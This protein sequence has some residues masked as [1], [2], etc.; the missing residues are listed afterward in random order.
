TAGG[1]ESRDGWLLEAQEFA[2]A[3][4]HSRAFVCPESS[5][6]LQL[7]GHMELLQI[8]VIVGALER[9]VQRPVHLVEP[10]CPI[11]IPQFCETLFGKPPGLLGFAGPVSGWPVAC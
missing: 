3:R 1:S 11:K 6:N 5:R 9:G 10:L 7:I 4:P 8:A 2:D